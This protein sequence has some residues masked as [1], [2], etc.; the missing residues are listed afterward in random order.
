MLNYQ[1]VNGDVRGM[2]KWGHVR[3]GD[4]VGSKMGVGD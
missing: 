4:W 2:K 1:R 3:Y